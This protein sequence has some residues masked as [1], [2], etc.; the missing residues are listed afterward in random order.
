MLFQPNSRIDRIRQIDLDEH[1]VIEVAGDFLTEGRKPTFS[2]CAPE[3]QK[4]DKPIRQIDLDEHK[5][6]EV[7]GDFLTEGRKPTFSRCA[8]EVQ[9]KRQTNSITLWSII[10]KYLPN[11]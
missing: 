2:R 8:P 4:S 10:R 1:K 3:V 7:A 5:V 9:K 11:N 6:I